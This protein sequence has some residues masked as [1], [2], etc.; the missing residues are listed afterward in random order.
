MN[1]KN[2][3]QIKVEVIPVSTLTWLEEHLEVQQGAFITLNVIALD[4]FGRKF[5]NCTAVT[6]Q[7]DMK[8]DGILVQTDISTN[9]AEIRESV[10][11]NKPLMFMR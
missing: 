4:T 3:A 7:F 9:Y 5:T 1:L 2:F 6:P 11:D 10:L 8:G